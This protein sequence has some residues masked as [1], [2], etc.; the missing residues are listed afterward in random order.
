MDDD[1]RGT[2]MSEALRLTRAGQLTE[3]F[4]VLQRGG[5]VMPPANGAIRAVPAGCSTRC[6]Q[7]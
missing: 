5:H 3:A 1:H 6:G 7:R 2:G 4:A